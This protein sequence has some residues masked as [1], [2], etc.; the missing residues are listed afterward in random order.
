MEMIFENYSYKEKN[1]N[2]TI[3]HNSIIGI[4]GKNINDILELICLHSL[5]KGNLTIN[6]IKT[7][8]DNIKVFRKR[9][10]FVK[11]NID[12]KPF[13]STVLDLMLNEIKT[14]GFSLNDPNKKII[15]SLKIVGLESNY[16]TRDIQTLSKYE[17]KVIQIAIMLLSNPNVIILHEPFKGID[18]KNEKKIM[19]LLQKIK[20]QYQKTIIIASDDSN[21]LYKYTIDMIF[22]KNGEIFLQ[23][24]TNEVYTRV[25]YLKRNKFEIPEIVEFTYLAK[26]N[27]KVKIDYHKD[28]R[29]IIKDIYKHV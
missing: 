14:K 13:C 10:G 23:G 1:I 28:I 20:E 2:L 25:D 18:I 21:I 16:L 17:K 29:D 24:P 8:T 6:D 7:N 9:I 12:N 3:K 11:E 15:D 5:G 4:T 26:K 22:I 19:S 27:K